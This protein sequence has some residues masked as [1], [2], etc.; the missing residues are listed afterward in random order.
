MLRWVG[1]CCLV[2]TGALSAPSYQ[3]P[4]PL[5]PEEP[6]RVLGAVTTGLHAPDG[7]GLSRLDT[8]FGFTHLATQ[9]LEWGISVFGGLQ[10]D[11]KLF[12]QSDQIEGHAGLGLMGRM[13]GPIT[14]A[15][16]MGLQLEFDYNHSFHKEKVKHFGGLDF[17]AGLPIGYNIVNLIRLY[18][19]PQ[20]LLDRLFYKEPNVADATL[21]S[22]LRVGVAGRTGMRVLLG[23]ASLVLE[24]EPGIRDPRNSKTFYTD[25]LVGLSCDL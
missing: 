17:K 24:V 4:V 9:G 19:M 8:G 12:E 15:F 23:F 14:R 16:F 1:F 20:L 21:F 7:V 22:S 2:S 18:V 6:L 5:N 10:S 11:S 3:S 13:L 25:F